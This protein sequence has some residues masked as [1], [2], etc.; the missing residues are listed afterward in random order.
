MELQEKWKSYNIIKDKL[1]Y[2]LNV[3]SRYTIDVWNAG[4][5]ELCKTVKRR[6]AH[7]FSNLHNIQMVTQL[8]NI[9]ITINV[10]Q[11]SLRNVWECTVFLFNLH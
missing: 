2:F 6:Q 10:E 3:V 1:L 8:S 11:V 7:F 5:S 4:S 9:G